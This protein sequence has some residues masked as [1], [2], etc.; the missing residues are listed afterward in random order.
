MSTNKPPKKVVV[1]TTQTESAKKVRFE[2]APVKDKK[3]DQL[4][5]TRN[6]YYWMALGVG[7]I[8]L[9]MAL[10]SGGKMP[11]PSVW[12]ENII[13]SARRTVLAPILILVG[14]GVEVYAIFKK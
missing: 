11:D 7:I 9:G 3:A 12:D 1:S 10:M 14:L 13:Y 4:V 6:N 2:P 5:F 8:A